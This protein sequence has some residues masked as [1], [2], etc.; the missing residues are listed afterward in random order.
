MKAWRYTLLRPAVGCLLGQSLLSSAG[1]SGAAAL[2]L[3][4]Q[5]QAEGIDA[6]QWRLA[7]QLPV[8]LRWDALGQPS[9]YLLDG[10]NLKWR[11][12][13][14]YPKLVLQA[15]QSL[16]LHLPRGEY[17]RLHST[18]LDAA[19]LSAKLSV[20]SNQAN[21]LAVRETLKA[22]DDDW[23]LEKDS[24]AA[25]IIELHAAKDAEIELAV[26]VSRQAELPELAPYRQVLAL[27]GVEQGLRADSMGAPE[28]YWPLSPSHTQSVRVRG[29]ARLALHTRWQFQPQDKMPAQTWQ[30]ELSGVQAKT[31]QFDFQGQAEHAELLWLNGAPSLLS[32][33]QSAYFNLPA[34]E[35]Q[36]SLRSNGPLLARLVQQEAND[37]VFAEHNA[38]LDL[39][40]AQ[41]GNPLGTGLPT[42]ENWSNDASTLSGALQTGEP[43]QIK[44]A[45]TRLQQDNRHREGSLI[46]ANLL[47]AHALATAHESSQLKQAEQAVL[48]SQSQWQD[49][50]PTSKLRREPPRLAW[51]ATQNLLPLGARANGN[52]IAAQHA[53]QLLAGLQLGHFL[54]LPND[55]QA[56]LYHLPARQA[57]SQLQ[58][59]LHVARETKQN[60]W[61]QLDN[62]AP[63]EIKLSAAPAVDTLANS[64]ALSALQWQSMQNPAFAGSTTDAAFSK[65]ATPA[66]LLAARVLHLAVPRH[67]Q[68]VKIWR[69]VDEDG[70]QFEDIA[71][72]NQMWLSLKLRSAQPFAMAENNLLAMLQ[73]SDGLASLNA[74]LAT[75]TTPTTSSALDSHLQPLVRMLR[76][77]AD[78]FASSVSKPLPAPVAPVAPFAPAAKQLEEQIKLAQQLA[79]DGNW[80]AALEQWGKIPADCESSV[81]ATS[82]QGRTTALLALGEHFLAEQLLKQQVLYGQHTWATQKL[83]QLY[84]EQADTRSMLSLAA[85]N[86]LRQPEAAQL[87]QLVDALQAEQHTELAMQ[88]A[89]LLPAK[90]RPLANMLTM[91][92]QLKKW[93]NLS[94]EL[95]ASLPSRAAR[96]F[97]L[98]QQLAQEMQ[99]EAA[100]QSFEMSALLAAQSKD[101]ALAEQAK[102][103]AAHLQQGLQLHQSIQSAHKA[104]TPNTTQNPLTPALLETWAQWQAQHPGPLSWQELAGQVQDFAGAVSLY[105]INRD[106]ASTSYRSQ[107][108]QPVKVRVLGPLR[109]R[110]EARPLHASNRQQALEGW[111]KIEEKTR[112][113]LWPV[114]ILQNWPATGLKLVGNTQEM[115]GQLVTRE[116]ELAA[117]WHEL[118]VSGEQI[119]LLVNL[120]TAVP[121]LRLPVLPLLNQDSIRAQ[122][123]PELEMMSSQ[124][125]WLKPMQSACAGCNTVLL[126]TPIGSAPSAESKQMLRWRSKAMPSHDFASTT[127]IANQPAQPSANPT[128]AEMLGRQA[129]QQILETP[130]GQT[131]SAVLETVSALLWRHEHASHKTS[132]ASD[133]QQTGVAI[134]SQIQAEHPELS[135]LGGLMERFTRNSEWV[136]QQSV[137]SSAGQRSRPIN[138][139]EPEAP[140]IRVRR[141]L[142]PPLQP[143]EYLLSAGNRLVLSLFNLKAGQMRL[144]LAKHEVGALPPQALQA[145]V[146]LD[147]GPIETI[148]LSQEVRYVQWR[149]RLKDGVQSLVVGV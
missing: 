55:D 32:E 130:V 1:L 140:A 102:Q 125:E 110:I 16:R 98:A 36:L 105:S 137:Q 45:A 61:L 34:G 67:V 112:Q 117:G 17:L 103:F 40:A 3:A 35:H 86:F 29:P 65:N 38:E 122:A 24:D 96:E 116:I 118:E 14:R 79:N 27:S 22:Q 95:R 20:W 126:P 124:R 37:Y 129:W 82:L 4:A 101:T 71:S 28:S 115:P 46:A 48:Q 113:M 73:D 132:A 54:P 18:A 109:L 123:K 30:V 43:D 57:D 69:G 8:S 87:L 78:L 144:R 51:Y 2:L 19:K 6:V 75:P 70:A 66:P 135:G 15:G 77:Q 89:L 107:A 26:F 85:S 84:T 81:C 63:R 41:V 142:L 133:W 114:P 97:W 94:A 111:L 147:Q 146:Q 11:N 83:A 149:L 106:I 90:Q 120:K 59:A 33:L 9:P 76:S 62:A 21:R 145:Q 93:P 88:A 7:Q 64:N 60:L 143:Q 136:L 134:A 5:A 72:A 50:L 119:P 31:I 44:Q 138:S 25:R 141:A 58:I 127:P 80:L 42:P 23:L 10:Q 108:G 91:A 121:A 74:A 148:T 56:Q 39:A 99:F 100:T 139:W 12:D 47:R 49:V 53:E 131:P 92:Q 68:Q 128:L 52:I 13:G 104:T